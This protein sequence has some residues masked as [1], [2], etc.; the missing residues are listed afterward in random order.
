MKKKR[1]ADNGD[2]QA[3]CAD[4]FA[5][6]TGLPSMDHA[7]PTTTQPAADAPPKCTQVQH[8]LPA[9]KGEASADSPRRM[10]QGIHGF[11]PGKR[12]RGSPTVLQR[13][14]ASEQGKVCDNKGTLSPHKRCH[15][16]RHRPSLTFADVC[17]LCTT[18]VMQIGVGDSIIPGIRCCARRR[19]S[20][21]KAGQR[22][23]LDRG[24]FARG[25]PD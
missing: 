2:V 24:D 18:L 22:E 9:S 1:F 5:A 19:D 15:S 13:L 21:G 12:W 20:G 10:V 3:T 25:Q 23:G 17:R 14:G 16:D 8:H 7:K 4:K 11:A 6:R